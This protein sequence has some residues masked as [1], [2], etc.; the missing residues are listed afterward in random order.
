[1]K[2]SHSPLLLHV[3]S[4]ISWQLNAL[5][6]AT[7]MFRNATAFRQNL[8]PW[9]T[10]LVNKATLVSTNMFA[11]SNCLNKASPSTSNTPYGPLCATCA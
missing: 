8:C 7:N 9:S 2:L 6:T 1:M 11:S 10:N 3:F 4:S 5:K